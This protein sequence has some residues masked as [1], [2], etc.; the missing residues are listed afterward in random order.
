[1][2][3]FGGGYDAALWATAAGFAAFGLISIGALVLQDWR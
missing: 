3:A 1:V 2:L